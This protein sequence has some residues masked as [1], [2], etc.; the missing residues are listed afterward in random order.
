MLV[1]TS[2]RFGQPRACTYNRDSLLP[3][4]VRLIVAP[5]LLGRHWRGIRREL[6][7][8]LVLHSRVTLHAVEEGLLTDNRIPTAARKITSL[9]PFR[10][11][12][13]LA[14]RL[15]A[16]QHYGSPYPFFITFVEERS[17][18]AQISRTGS[19]YTSD[20]PIPDICR[21]VEKISP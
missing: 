1:S 5:K 4:H 14:P 3:L 8:L 7:M 19:R 2:V 18:P 16:A 9:L 21:S 15:L 12:R 13:N 6:L 10:T 20:A 17:S 11:A